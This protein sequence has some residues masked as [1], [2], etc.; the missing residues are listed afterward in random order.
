MSKKQRIKRKR[1]EKVTSSK[2]WS[3]SNADYHKGQ[4]KNKNT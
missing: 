1:M 4:N 3:V 2:Q